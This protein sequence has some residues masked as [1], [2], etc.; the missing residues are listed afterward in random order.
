MVTPTRNRFHSICPYFAMFPETFPEQWISQLTR[1]GDL[2][3]DPFCGRGTTPFSAML[4]NR[5]AV[6]SDVND[7]AYC[8]TKAK[9]A[10]PKLRGLVR[11]IDTLESSFDGRAWRHEADQLPEF[12]Q[13]AYHKRTLQQLV[14]LRRTLR[15]KTLKTDGMVAALMLGS[16]HGEA[17]SS[18]AYFSNQ[19]PRTISTKPAYSIRFWEERGLEPPLRNVFNVLRQRAHFRYESEPPTGDCVVLHRDVRKL[20]WSDVELPQPIR[21]VVTS[22]PYFDVTNF[23]EDQWLRLWALGGPPYPTRGRV[24]RDDRHGFEEHY[25]RFLADMWRC[26]G[27]VLARRAH[28]VIR[29]GSSRI[30]PQ[31]LVDGLFTSASF[32]QRET[33]LVQ[34]E[35]SELKN[36]QTNSFLPGTKG[37]SCEVDCHFYVK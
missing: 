19:M 21:C 13:R 14:Y 26:L 37:C 2:V 1:P 6:A 23:E 30:T 16:L 35:V 29:I 33:E 12:F 36:R 22:P 15:W 10:A 34:S 24:S 9:T 8:L 3:L 20:S 7:V 32:S 11:R 4:L 28:V 31:R 5:R 27:K 25:W 18:T 17:D